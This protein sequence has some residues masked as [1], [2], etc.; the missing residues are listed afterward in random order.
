MTWKFWKKPKEE[1]KLETTM[2]AVPMTTLYRWY[3]Y[4]IGM[5]NTKTLDK[6]IG[7]MPIS[8]ELA[9]KEEQE[10]LKRLTRIAP[11]MP[12]LNTI[13]A[14][15]STVF[16]EQHLKLMMEVNPLL[17]NMPEEA[18]EHALEA[19]TAMYE[20]LSVSALVSAFSSSI[21][22]GLVTPAMVEIEEGHMDDHPDLSMYE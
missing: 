19:M 20:Y 14:I 16:T 13:A 5:E 22:L 9:E 8:D 11:L 6:A 7:V 1:V 3:C 21:E 2:K 4:D 15:N 18:R 17:E 12:F 10:S